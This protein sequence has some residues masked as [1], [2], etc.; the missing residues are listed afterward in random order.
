MFEKLDQVDVVNFIQESL[1][2]ELPARFLSRWK[3]ATFTCHLLTT[4]AAQIP[5]RSAEFNKKWH[6]HFCSSCCWTAADCGSCC[7]SR[8]SS[9]GA[10]ACD[11]SSRSCSS[12]DAYHRV[13]SSA[14]VSPCR[15]SV[16]CCALTVTCP[17]A[18]VRTTRVP[19]YACFDVSRT[20]P[21]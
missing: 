5:G 7:C 1:K 20:L 14:D 2:S 6:V 18:C 11:P 21:S 12:Y 15:G 9:C 3:F 16:A 8:T 10:C 4:S 17:V 13:V 19:R